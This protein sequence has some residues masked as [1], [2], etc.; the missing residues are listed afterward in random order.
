[1]S[2]S[3]THTISEEETLHRL[4]KTL[5][6]AWPDLSRSRI[7]ALIKDGRV[8]LDGRAA[9]ASELP[10]LG[11][12]VE[13]S[14]PERAEP[15]DGRLAPE[16]IPLSIVY[17]DDDL[18]VVDKPA[19]LVVHPGA[20][21]ASG[22]LAHALLAHCPAIEGVGGTGRPGLVHRI[23]RGTT[24]LLVV[25]KSEAAWR[26][27]TKDLAAR[28]IQ[29]T[30]LALVWGVPEPRAG[31]IE[32]AIAR[33][34]KE[35]TRMAVV[36]LGKFGARPAATNYRVVAELPSDAQRPRYA[37]LECRLE[38]GRTHQIRV[39][40]ASVKHPVVGDATYG[41]GGKKALSLPPAERTL[42]TRLV[43]DLGRPALHAVSLAFRHPTRGEAMTFRAP[44]PH[45]MARALSSLG[46]FSHP[47][48]P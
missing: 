46:L 38:T 32:A 28:E 7:A 25:A 22:T 33:D 17:E 44:L 20:G 40:F 12:R 41:G 3:R 45:D 27:L 30:Y 1:M 31:R 18:L 13:A 48:C 4:D 5:A 10:S 21:V 6:R 37:L 26:G 42:A 43:K 9:K 39:H 14:L 29:R 23:D 34:R 11:A 47:A 15:G 8:T 24:G 16:A 35:R 36:P 19:G 2:R